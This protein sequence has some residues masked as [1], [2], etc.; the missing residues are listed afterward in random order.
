ML[1]YVNIFTHNRARGYIRSRWD[2]TAM[3]MFYCR[4]D[5]NEVSRLPVTLNFPGEKPPPPKEVKGKQP[6]IK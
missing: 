6:A 1:R 2:K 5:L 4:K 3:Q